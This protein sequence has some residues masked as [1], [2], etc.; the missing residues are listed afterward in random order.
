MVAHNLKNYANN[1]TTQDLVLSLQEDQ[2]ITEPPLPMFIISAQN[3]LTT[4]NNIQEL[5]QTT[6]P[7]QKLKPPTKLVITPLCNQCKEQ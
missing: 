6:K 5:F 3:Q 1:N 7:L 2:D 4:P